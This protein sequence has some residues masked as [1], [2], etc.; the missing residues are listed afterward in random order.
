M[1]R[2]FPRAS[3]E[4]GSC[5]QAGCHRNP[6]VRIGCRIAAVTAVECLRSRAAGQ[7]VVVNPALERVIAGS[8]PLMT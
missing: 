7:N 4:T 5:I 1:I 2:F 8:A 6:G 3:S